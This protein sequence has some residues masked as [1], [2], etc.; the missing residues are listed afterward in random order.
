MTKAFYCQTIFH[1]ISILFCREKAITSFIFNTTEIELICIFQKLLFVYLGSSQDC[2]S[3][4]F[5][6]SFSKSLGHLFYNFKKS[7]RNIPFILKT[8]VIRKLQN[9]SPY[10][11][12]R[13]NTIFSE[14]VI[15][16]T[17]RARSPQYM[18]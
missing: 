16:P 15:L 2:T 18:H 13:Y 12:P 4:H 17:H 8:L 11:L 6:T 9:A 10:F 14:G 7:V 1:L 5:I 3:D